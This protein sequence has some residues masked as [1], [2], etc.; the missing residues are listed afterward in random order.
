MNTVYEIISVAALVY[1][2]IGTWKIEKRLSQ[3][4]DDMQTIRELL[5]KWEKD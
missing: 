4:S 2:C 5:E 3:V 1:F